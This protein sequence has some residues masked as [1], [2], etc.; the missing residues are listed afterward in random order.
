M[1]PYY[2]LLG[3]PCCNRNRP[4]SRLQIQPM[5]RISASFG[6]R[7]SRSL[8]ACICFRIRKENAA[9]PGTSPP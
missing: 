7:S 1:L 9:P 5:I 2:L 8:L 6:L 4:L 3:L